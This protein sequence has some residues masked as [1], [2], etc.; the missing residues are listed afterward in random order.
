MSGDQGEL[1]SEDPAH[2]QDGAVWW[3]GNWQCRNWHGLLQHR[4]GGQGNWCFLVHSFGGDPDAD[5]TAWLHGI[6]GKTPVPIDRANRI[7]V[8]G[9]WYGRE[10]WHH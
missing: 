4:E 1:F 8:E 9:K 3:A 10:R 5:G 2:T 7:L 6:D